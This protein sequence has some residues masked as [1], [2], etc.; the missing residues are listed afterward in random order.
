M[1][2]G[3]KIIYNK[4]NKNGHTPVVLTIGKTYEII[5]TKRT[6]LNRV[7]IRDDNGIKRWYNENS[8]N[9]HFKLVP[10]PDPD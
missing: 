9:C 10:D 1:K 3:T 4:R 8:I 5:D 2:T 6:Y 7:S